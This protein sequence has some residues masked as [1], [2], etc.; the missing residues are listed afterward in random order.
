MLYVEGVN[1]VS[2]SEP[3]GAAKAEVAGSTISAAAA[4]VPLG[5]SGLSHAS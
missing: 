5:V 3:E 1:I 2:V 4:G